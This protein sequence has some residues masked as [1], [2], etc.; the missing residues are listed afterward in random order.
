MAFS[1]KTSSPV[2]EPEP[3]WCVFCATVTSRGLRTHAL[4][5]SKTLE[6]G[7]KQTET[8]HRFQYHSITSRNP[9]RSSIR[10][11]SHLDCSSL[12]FDY[13]GSISRV[14]FPWAFLWGFRTKR[15][16][17]CHIDGQAPF[18]V[19]SKR[20]E[21][22]VFG[23]VC[24]TKCFLFWTRRCLRPL[25]LPPAQDSPDPS[26]SISGVHEQTFFVPPFPKGRRYWRFPLRSPL[27]SR[28][29]TSFPL[30]PRVDPLSSPLFYPRSFLPDCGGTL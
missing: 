30:W 28:F 24:K 11:P 19:F 12:E 29:L 21:G 15:H 25:N 7:V 26:P 23:Y 10:T 13:L 2:F 8:E 3:T 18:N 14:V 6:I 17:S 27:A 22:L 16:S 1:P 5:G 4:H 9:L 20:F